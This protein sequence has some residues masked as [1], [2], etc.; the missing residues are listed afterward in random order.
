[1]FNKSY[2][3]IVFGLSSMIAASGILYFDLPASIAYT[4]LVA[5]FFLIGIGILLGFFQM[6]SDDENNQ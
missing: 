5:G 3:V 2:R 6:V 1:M 4:L